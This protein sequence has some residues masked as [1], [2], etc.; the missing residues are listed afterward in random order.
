MPVTI[1]EVLD[2]L[3]AAGWS[4]ARDGRLNYMTS[5]GDWHYEDPA[6]ETAARAA[7]NATLAAGSVTAISLWAPEGHGVNTLFFPDARNISFD[8]TLNRRLLPGSG[9]ATD[10]GWYLSKLSPAFVGAGLS[11]VV[12]KDGR[13]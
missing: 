6:S 9:M 8:L 5:G 3:T 10:L 4:L 7:M 11:A 1:D 13:P 12:A 2:W